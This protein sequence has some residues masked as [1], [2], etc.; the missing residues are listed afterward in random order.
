MEKA[1]LL[2]DDG[3]LLPPSDPG[4]RSGD[5]VSPIPVTEL[6]AET[7][8]F[9]LLAAGG[10]GKSVTC[11]DLAKAEQGARRID[12]AALTIDGLERE[13]DDACLDE[14]AV[15]LDSLDQSASVEPRLLPWLQRY[16]TAPARRGTRWRLACRAAVWD[17][18]LGRALFRD[19]PAFSVW[20]LAP[21]DRDA[22]TEAVEGAVDA[23]EFD[24]AAFMKDLVGARLGRL[25][26]CV[27]Q[28]VAVARY[29]SEQ[30][31][32]PRS[33]AD[34]MKF[35]I[36]YLLRETDERRQPRLPMDRSMRLAQRLGA[37]TMF[38]G[39]QAL[40]VGPVG[41][42][43]TLP[44][45]E[46]PSDPE[47]DQL[48]R[49]IEPAD[50]R[51][52]LDTALFDPGPA[53][54]VVFKH[55]RHL[56]YLAAAY[57]VERGIRAGQIPVLLGVHA[58]GV[59]P[60]ARIGVASWL[61]ALAPDLVA[62]LF[63]DNAAMFA[64]T[65]AVVELPSDEARAALV[66]GLLEAAAQDDAEPDWRLDR[67]GLLH[68]G[69]TEQLA[70]YLARGPA[71]AVQ[72]WWIARLAAAGNCRAVAHAL[73][74][75]ALKT[76][77]VGYARRA[78]VAA[79]A[80]LDDEQV[81]LSL[82]ELL[83][84]PDDRDPD[85]D[86]EVRAAV[87][88]ALYPRLLS[89]ADLTRALRPHRSMLYGGYRQ[90]LRELSS[91]VPDHDVA[92]FVTW[93]AEHTWR[94]DV[95]DDDQF[96][97]LRVGVIDRAWQQVGDDVVRGQLA[98]LLVALVRSG[99]WH[100][101]SARNQRRPWSEGA[102]EQRRALAVDAAAVG[103]D[104]WY[105]VLTLGL[106]TGE[107]AEWLL[108][109]LPSVAPQA[110]AALADCLPQLLHSP[111]AALADRVLEL[112]PDHPGHQ[113]TAFLRTEVQIDDESVQPQRHLAAEDYKH[114]CELAAR[115]ERVRGDLRI[116]LANLAA[117]PG[118][119]WRI[120]WLLA[121]GTGNYDDIVE[122]TASDLTR[123]PG[124]AEFNIDER[125]LVLAAGLVYLH[126]HHPS[127]A[128]WWTAKTWTSGEVLP[129][130]SGVYLLATLA[131]HFS[132]LLDGL[133]DEVWARWMPSIVATPVFGGDDSIGPRRRLLDAVPA[134]LRQQL[135]D[136]ALEHLA[137]HAAEG[138]SLTP[139]AVYIHLARELAPSIAERLL[140]APT[141]TG[142]DAEL[143]TLLVKDGTPGTAL[144][145]CRQLI[146][147]NSPLAPHARTHLAKLDPDSVI[148]A[149]AAAPPPPDELAEAV[150]NLDVALLDPARLAVA[151]RLLLDRHPYAEDQPLESGFTYTPWHRASDLRRHVLDRMALNGRS[152]ELA[153]LSHGR[154][155]ADQQAL[156]YYYR[157]ARARQADLSLGTTPP[158]TLLNLLRR[159]DARLVRDDADLQHVLLQQLDELQHY[160]AGAWREIW[161]NGL[162]QTEDDVSD[163]LERRLD[164]RLDELIIDREVQV[165]RRNRGVGTRIDLIATTKTVDGDKARVF[166]EAKRIDN[167]E[168][169][170][171]MKNQL[172]DRYLIP[173]NR[174]HGIYLVYW[175]T[176]DQRPGGW[177]RTN[178][179]DR[180]TLKHELDEQ[181]R[182]AAETGF[183]IMPYILDIS[184]P[185]AP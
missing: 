40:T 174:R 8:S 136:A 106:L 82:R 176:P 177:S 54:S 71:N 91:R 58:N 70:E 111:S 78:A 112:A 96:D 26:G 171:A 184:C 182:Q 20:K 52:V 85:A 38:A 50:Y 131:E 116:A 69:L 19:L 63:T 74:R 72:L 81:L 55:Q 172:I 49:T 108:D 170:T 138:G 24:A 86:N 140:A 92:A 118:S 123:R 53:G 180:A 32:L 68:A 149:L 1:V 17:A 100:R 144:A 161:D 164:E 36:E 185:E 22:A 7:A 153:A 146:K 88:D 107:D 34:A 79:V 60:N 29:W 97:D 65:A 178:A 59:L 94:N 37:F 56:E 14:S 31:E 105:A 33:A 90:T 133:P 75:A 129:D 148:D 120:P 163:W 128:T 80:E 150:Q 16:L 117:E 127:A 167:R 30:G 110:K 165:R 166:V 157:I 45:G 21:L 169:M 162:P 154:P 35:E 67:A 47:P 143:V 23:S 83:I 121:G 115:R 27:G 109:T 137:A 42:R 181:A 61:A 102:P 158:R 114:Q 28:L 135:I 168:L 119:W 62:R 103:E 51:A 156:A 152:E 132:E 10:A 89:T 139:H 98:R 43:A 151:A 25:S 77:W 179:A 12:T 173:K 95:R 84:V 44:V 160:L 125:R 104:T 122:G 15:Y 113:A 183:L 73:A 130:W 41:N 124:W 39:N 142:L 46:L 5:A 3:F 2:D 134:Q 159:G 87:I 57:L 9:A 147:I 6:L 48:A 66:K 4:W 145:T 93:L 175:I 18:V 155:D 64:S 13:L 99:R 11:T 141:E 126:T 101:P 76:E